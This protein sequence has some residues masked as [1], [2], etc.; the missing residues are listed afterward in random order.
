MFHAWDSALEGD[1]GQRGGHVLVSEILTCN[2][3][4]RDTTKGKKELAIART[5]GRPDPPS[6]GSEDL[7]LLKMKYLE[8][9]HQN[10]Q[11]KIS[12]ISCLWNPYFD[13]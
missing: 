10:V 12:L 7:R 8:R 4:E 6:Y 3:C 11:N 9:V 1:R 2:A 13:I 5:E